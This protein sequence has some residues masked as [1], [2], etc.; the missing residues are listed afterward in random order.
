MNNPKLTGIIKLEDLPQ[1]EI[2]VRLE[3]ESFKYIINTLKEKYGLTNFLIKNKL[4]NSNFWDW[5]TNKS[6]IRLD[7]LIK[8]KECLNL[9]KINIF[10][11]RG[12]QG[13]FIKKLQF[14]FKNSAGSRFIA[15]ILG[16]GCVH[17][18]GIRY[19]N[20]DINLINSFIDDTKQIFGEIDFILSRDKRGVY[21]V[22]LPTICMKIIKQLGIEPGSKISNNVRIPEFIY[23]LPNELITIFISKFIDDEGSINEGKLTIDLAFD[24]YNEPLL[25]YGLKDLLSKLNVKSSVFKVRDTYKS[26]R[27]RDRQMWRLGIFSYENLSKLKLD[28]MSYPKRDKFKEIINSPRRKVFNIKYYSDILTEA[29]KNKKYFTIYDISKLFNKNLNYSRKII[30]RLYKENKLY[31]IRTISNEN[32]NLSYNKYFIF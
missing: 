18:K 20:L 25:I 21:V 7:N 27:G 4:N 8:I 26:K 1:E 24:S 3:E 30:S 28:L 17:K 22:Y 15:S 11:F 19:I 16:D 6:L 14:D 23:F 5:R 32:S 31:S 12:K 29:S 13:K 9:R 10:S 2:Y